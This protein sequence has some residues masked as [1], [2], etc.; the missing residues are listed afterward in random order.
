MPETP[1]SQTNAPEQLAAGGDIAGIVVGVVVLVLLLLFLLFVAFRWRRSQ[2]SGV[3]E[4][5]EAKFADAVV[6]KDPEFDNGIGSGGTYMAAAQWDLFTDM[7]TEDDW[8]LLNRGG[9]RSQSPDH[10]VSLADS[11]MIKLSESKG[12]GQGNR[13]GHLAMSSDFDHGTSTDHWLTYNV[14]SVMANTH[15]DS[16]VAAHPDP[17]NGHATTG[18][19]WASVRTA[20]QAPPPAGGREG[21]LIELEDD[22][23]FPE[24]DVEMVSSG[25]DRTPTSADFSEDG[26]GQS[27]RS[28]SHDA[29]LESGGAKRSPEGA[30][31]DMHDEEEFSF[32]SDG[33]GD[34]SF[35]GVAAAVLAAAGMSERL[36]D[37]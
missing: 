14:P 9:Q 8:Q 25:A 23:L 17:A 32:V 10:E 16:Y 37:V 27:P 31:L 30:L 34:I 7:P 11:I 4:V 29:D 18:G 35:R 36:T 28:L 2:N 19:E 13:S 6:T 26:S 12:D 3:Y 21:R 20:E 24:A 5:D 33:A 1:I 22:L 15:D